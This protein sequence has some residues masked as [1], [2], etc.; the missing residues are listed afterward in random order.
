MTECS[1]ITRAKKPCLNKGWEGTNFCHAH[2]FQ[3]FRE[4]SAA[5]ASGSYEKVLGYLHKKVHG[6]LPQRLMMLVAKYHPH[7]SRVPVR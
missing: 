2:L 6:L 4:I 3:V 7:K 5:N 1:A